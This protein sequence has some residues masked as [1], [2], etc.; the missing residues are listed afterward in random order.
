MSVCL[1][2]CQFPCISISFAYMDGAEIWWACPGYSKNFTFPGGG[3]IMQEP[4][5]AFD[6]DYITQN[7]CTSNC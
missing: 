1:S 6:I 2:V 7:N 3:D 5:W 4:I